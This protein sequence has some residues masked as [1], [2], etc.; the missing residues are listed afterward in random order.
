MW[1]TSDGVAHTVALPDATD[2]FTDETAAAAGHLAATMGPDRWDSLIE[3]LFEAAIAVGD[4]HPFSADREKEYEAV[5]PPRGILA[6]PVRDAGHL[7]TAIERLP[8]RWRLDV[9]LAMEDL[10]DQ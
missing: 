5:T 1:R 8:W 4:E 9:V 7:R 6:A 3:E 2:P 10:A